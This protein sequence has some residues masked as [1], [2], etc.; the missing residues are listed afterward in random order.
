M[1][2]LGSYEK[3]CRGDSAQISHEQ[4]IYDTETSPSTQN[5]KTMSLWVFFF[6]YFSSYLFLFNVR[7]KF[8][9]EILMVC[10]FESE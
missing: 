5:F 6:T 9:F 1:Y 4:I 3:K 7:L 8:T 10:I 2:V